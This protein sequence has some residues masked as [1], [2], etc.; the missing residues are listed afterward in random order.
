MLEHARD[1]CAGRARH[2]DK[3]DQLHD[4]GE[5]RDEHVYSQYVREHERYDDRDAIESEE[6]L[7]HELAE[8]PVLFWLD[9]RI[10]DEID[11][12]E[13]DEAGGDDDRH[14]MRPRQRHGDVDD[15][16]VQDD[17]EADDERGEEGVHDVALGEMGWPLLEELLLKILDLA[18]DVLHFPAFRGQHSLELAE[19]AFRRFPGLSFRCHQS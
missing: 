3:E 14:D 6:A 4:A 11:L 5:R 7:R 13:Q 15:P 12:R 9:A 8:L 17:R 2:R 16:P 19:L 10:A 1:G 18:L